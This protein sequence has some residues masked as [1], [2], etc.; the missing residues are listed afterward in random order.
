M[1]VESLFPSDD[2]SCGSS[3][4]SYNHIIRKSAKWAVPSC[5]LFLLTSE[6]IRTY[7]SLMEIFMSVD[8]LHETT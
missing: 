4:K 7:N 1:V 5:L 3:G 8:N 2:G 6:G